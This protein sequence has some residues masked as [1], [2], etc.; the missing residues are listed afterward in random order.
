MSRGQSL[1]VR[2]GSNAV[3]HMSRTQVNQLSSREV[4]RL[5]KLSSTNFIWS[6]WGVL[7]AWPAVKNAWRPTLGLTPIFTWVEPNS[8]QRS[9]GSN[10]FLPWKTTDQQHRFCY[11]F[12]D[13]VE[14]VRFDWI[15]FDVWLKQ[16]FFNYLSR[17]KLSLGLAHVKYSVWPGPKGTGKRG[18][19]VAD[20]LLL[21][22]YCM[23]CKLG[24][25]CCGHEMFLTKIRNIFCVPDTKFVSATNVA[26]GQMGKH[27]CRQQCVRKNV[28]SF[29][30][31]LRPGQIIFYTLYVQSYED[32]EMACFRLMW[33]E[34][35]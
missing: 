9:K 10:F 19:I 2:P 21:M 3:L 26:R 28:S 29:A 4:R 18:H 20:T 25:I 13:T 32:G 35:F 5:T 15:K 33:L 14:A 22:M 34:I 17:P 8:N 24:N 6:G 27:L 16:A 12:G 30:S 7:H 31:T 11:L 1:R 23:L